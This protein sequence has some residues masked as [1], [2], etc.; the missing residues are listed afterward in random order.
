MAEA[1]ALEQS[2]DALDVL[3]IARL[4]ALAGEVSEA[5]AWLERAVG[6]R[7]YGDLQIFQIPDLDPIRSS[8]Q[9]L[10]FRNRQ[11]HHRV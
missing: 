11:I 10:E 1:K 4:H 8:P 9:Y 3:T 7:T 2:Q 5:V 6:I